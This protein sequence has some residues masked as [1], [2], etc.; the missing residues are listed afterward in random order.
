MKTSSPVFLYLP[1]PT[2]ATM[3]TRRRLQLASFILNTNPSSALSQSPS[4]MPVPSSFPDARANEVLRPRAC[5]R[6]CSHSMLLLHCP[7]LVPYFQYSNNE[8]TK[9]QQ[10][11]TNNQTLALAPQVPDAQLPTPSHLRHSRLSSLAASSFAATTNAASS[12]S[13]ITSITASIDLTATTTASAA[14]TSAAYPLPADRPTLRHSRLLL[15]CLLL[16]RHRHRRTS[17]PHHHLHRSRRHRHRLRR[18]RL[19]CQPSRANRPPA[20]PGIPPAATAASSEQRAAAAAAASSS[21]QLQQG[22]QQQ[23]LNLHTHPYISTCRSRM[24][25]PYLALISHN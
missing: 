21:E 8:A 15:R 7:S 16:R 1:P 6:S 5:S 11:K 13:I 22:L 17:R 19:H 2:S 9:G 25:L 24:Y 18:L 23:R 14:L 3:P 20:A 4:S 10:P 12:A